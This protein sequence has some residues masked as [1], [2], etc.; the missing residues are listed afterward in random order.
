MKP[1]ISPTKFLLSDEPYIMVSVIVFVRSG[2][3]DLQLARA[4]RDTV[5]SI[6]AKPF[7]VAVP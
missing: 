1:H 3:I 7:L 2:G 5:P 6:K 4:A